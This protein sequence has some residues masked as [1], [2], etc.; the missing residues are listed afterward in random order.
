MT[1]FNPCVGL[2]GIDVHQFFAAEVQDPGLVIGEPRAWQPQ[3]VNVPDMRQPGFDLAAATARFSATIGDGQ[4]GTSP[5][6]FAPTGG[7][8]TRMPTPQVLP[9]PSPVYGEAGP[10]AGPASQPA[11]PSGPTSAG[12]VGTAV[13]TVLDKYGAQLALAAALGAVWWFYFRKKGR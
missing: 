12:H 7:A 11:T 9:G 13:G 1:H 8:V 4:W 2:R 3:P 5:Q 10:A 6:S